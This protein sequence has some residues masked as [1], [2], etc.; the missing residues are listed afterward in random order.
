VRA[1]L[2]LGA[3]SAAM[4]LLAGCS[5][6]AGPLGNGGTNGQQCIAYTEGQ[7][8]TAGLYELHNTDTSPVTVQNVS[9]PSSVHGLR[10]TKA[11]L[12]PIYR[13]PKSGDWVDV[14]VGAPYP[15]TSAPE[16]A[17]R[18]PAVGAVIEPGQNLNLVFGL[19]RTS[20]RVGRSA[21]PAIDYT[22]GGA[23]Y[24]LRE[25]VSLIVAGRCF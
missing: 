24:T 16:W 1:R 12:V 20:A 15:P 17:K 4:A 6:S 8:V 19:T 9:L 3:L 2:L 7:P 10:M 25:A 23:S 5:R 13:D 11:W 18:R 14:G 22:V 21:G